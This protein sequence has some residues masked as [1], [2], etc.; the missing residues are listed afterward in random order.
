MRSWKRVCWDEKVFSLL[1]NIRLPKVGLEGKLAFLLLEL[2]VGDKRLS[3][4]ASLPVGPLLP[5]GGPAWGRVGRSPVLSPR[6]QWSRG[7]DQAWE[8]PCLNTGLP[9]RISSTPVLSPFFA[10]LDV[11]APESILQHFSLYTI[12]FEAIGLTQQISLPTPEL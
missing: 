1:S 6:R 4:V 11:R 8:L 10:S 12:H 7:R 5:Q 9:T 3:A 2:G